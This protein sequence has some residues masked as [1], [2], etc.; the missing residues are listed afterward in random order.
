MSEARRRATRPHQQISR[1]GAKRARA[2]PGGAFR[3]GPQRDHRDRGRPRF[4]DPGP[5]PQPRRSHRPPRLLR[6]TVASLAQQTWS[7]SGTTGWVCL[8]TTVCRASPGPRMRSR[9]PSPSRGLE[10]SAAGT[11]GVMLPN[12]RTPGRG[13]EQFGV[14]SRCSRGST[15]VSAARLGFTD[16][17]RRARAGTGTWPTTSPASSTGNCWRT[18]RA[19]TARR[20]AR[21]RPPHRGPDRRAVQPGSRR[22]R[23]P[24]IAARAG[25]PTVIGQTLRGRED[26]ARHRPVPRRVPPVRVGRRAGVRDD[27]RDRRGRRQRTGGAPSPRPRGLVD[28]APPARTASFPPLPPTGSTSRALDMMFSQRARTPGPVCAVT[29][30][31]QGSRVADELETVIRRA[32]PGKVRPVRTTRRASWSRSAAGRDR[33]ADPG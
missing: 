18:S 19:P 28:G 16:G 30:S 10:A 33:A 24:R 11:G 29:S 14:L 1:P 17:V 32:A 12:H 25:L 20:Q 27:L 3:V 13:R 6:D 2:D 22:A 15:W 8:A 26:A 21:P 31:A 4:S 7:A 9:R 5:L 23:A